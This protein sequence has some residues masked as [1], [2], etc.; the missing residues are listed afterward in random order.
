MSVVKTAVR[1]PRPSPI[2]GTWYAGSPNQLRDSVASYIRE[3]Q[4]EVVPGRV[5]GLVAPHAGHIYSGPV[6]GYAYRQVEGNTYDVV[7]LIGP[8]HR[9]LGFAPFFTT[10]HDGYW[11]PLGEVPVAT[12]LLEELDR[13]VGVR[14]VWQDQEHSLEIQLPFLQVA[15]DGEFRLLPVMM[16]D[17]SEAA[18]RELGA[19]LADLLQGRR[20]LLIASSD[21]SHY[22]D[23][24]T[25][26][27]LD[28]AV[29]D[30]IAAFDPVGLLEVLE[31]GKGQACGGGPMATVMFAAQALGANEARLL[32]YA[33]SGDVTGDY[34][35]VV[36]YAAAVFYTTQHATRNT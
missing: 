36:G 19:A 27:R 33:T 22:Y 21:L 28:T 2:A 13:R 7:A 3:A 34:Y 16:R 29:T 25:A 18:C 32:H 15:L 10:A 14:R 35:A 31:T 8:D 11:T 6:A 12:D 17:Q 26:R 1:D 4:V 20:A 9:G 30:R 24:N 23:A 5:I